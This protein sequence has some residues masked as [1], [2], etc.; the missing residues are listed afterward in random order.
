MKIGL[1]LFGH[2]RSYRNTYNSFEELKT[3]LQKPGIELDIFC[4]TW[5]IEE[6][7][8]AAW[9]N[10]GESTHATSVVNE[11]EFITKYNPKSC[12]IETSREFDAP[13]LGIKSSIPLAGMYSMLYSQAKAFE[14]LKNYEKQSA[15]MY[16]VIVKTRYDLL[17]EFTPDRKSVV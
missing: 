13:D 15:Q 14:L 4:H 9:W 12:I 8:S 17:Y 3:I 11:T 16:D 5:D 1:I 2:L 10:N 7:V 6:S